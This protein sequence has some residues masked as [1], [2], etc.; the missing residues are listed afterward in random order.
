MVSTHCSHFKFYYSPMYIPFHDN[1]FIQIAILK[2]LAHKHS[3]LWN[4]P[5]EIYFSGYSAEEPSGYQAFIQ[6]SNGYGE[7]DKTV[8]LER[9]PSA[10]SSVV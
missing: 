7:E 4:Y 5:S 9:A 10:S 8:S 2:I 1:N 3:H 6:L